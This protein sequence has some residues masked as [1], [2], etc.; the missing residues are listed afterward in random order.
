MD[1]AQINQDLVAFRDHAH[2]LYQNLEQ[3][4]SL[5]SLRSEGLTFPREAHSEVELLLRQLQLLEVVLQQEG[6]FGGHWTPPATAYR[7]P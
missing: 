1:L 5:R 3:L 2:R 4:R 6:G 7:Q